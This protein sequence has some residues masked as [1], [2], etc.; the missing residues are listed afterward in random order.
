MDILWVLIGFAV[1]VLVSVM[2]LGRSRSGRA[3]SFWPWVDTSRG[4]RR[5]ETYVAEEEIN[6]RG[7]IR[8][9][10]ARLPELRKVEG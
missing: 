1:A 7:Q 6:H 3:M 8:W 9:R 10:R 5:L 2:V 4:D